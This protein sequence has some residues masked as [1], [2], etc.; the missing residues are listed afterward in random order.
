MSLKY[1]DHLY[2]LAFIDI[3]DRYDI[4]LLEIRHLQKV[5]IDSL[6]AP[7]LFLPLRKEEDY[8]FGGWVEDD[9]CC[10][11]LESGKGYAKYAKVAS[12]CV[13]RYPSPSAAVQYISTLSK[14]DLEDSHLDMPEKLTRFIGNLWAGDLWAGGERRHYHAL[15]A[16]QILKQQIIKDKLIFLTEAKHANIV[17]LKNNTP[18]RCKASLMILRCGVFEKINSYIGILR[19]HQQQFGKSLDFGLQSYPRPGIERR[20]DIG[21]YNDFLSNRTHDL[22]KDMLHFLNTF[23]DP[24]DPE[25][26]SKRVKP[27]ILHGWS[28]STKV[29][30]SELLDDVN[31]A[32]IESDVK[33]EG[34]KDSAPQHVSYIDTSF[35]SPDRPDLQPLVAKH[36][37]I[38]LARNYLGG[39]N[40]NFLSNSEDPF[41]HLLVSLH[42][43][44]NTFTAE[45]PELSSIKEHYVS[46]INDELA[47]DF[48]AASVKG[49][50]YIYA[51]FLSILGEGLEDQLRTLDKSIKLETLDDLT[52]AVRSYESHFVWYFRLR[53]TAYFLEKATQGRCSASDILILKGTREVC[54]DILDFLDS[55]VPSSTAGIPVGSLWKKLAE[56]MEECIKKHAFV[57]IAKKWRVKRSE[58]TWCEKYNT[59]GDKVYHRSTIRLDLRLQRFLFRGTLQQKLDS[60]HKPLH[61]YK[62]RLNLL[63]NEKYNEKRNKRLRHQLYDEFRDIYGLEIETIP[64][65]GKIKTEYS[66]PRW[67][68]R[69]LHHIPF[70]CAVMRSI[71]LLGSIHQKEKK[72]FS[73]SWL[74]QKKIIT[75]KHRPKPHS[76]IKFITEIHSDMSLGREKF[77]MGLE[78]Y[79]WARESPRERLALSNN[80]IVFILPQLDGGLEVKQHLTDWLQGDSSHTAEAIRETIKCQS[81]GK[82]KKYYSEIL[83]EV[84]AENINRAFSWI[85]GG[86]CSELRRLDQLAGY[87][88]KALL[89]IYYDYVEAPCLENEKNKES[90]N[91]LLAL[92][93][94][95][96]IRADEG[97]EKFYDL[98]LQA[99][100]NSSPNSVLP[101]RIPPVMLSRAVLTNYYA[102]ADPFASFDNPQGI[103]KRGDEK[104][105]DKNKVIYNA[106][107]LKHGMTLGNWSVT[108]NNDE[109]SKFSIILGRYDVVGITPARMPCKC[110]VLNFDSDFDEDEV[111]V[112]HFTRREVALPVNIYKIADKSNTTLFGIISISL[113]RRAMRLNLLYRVLSALDKESNKEI[114]PKVESSIREMVDRYSD[115]L[116]IQGY[117]TDGWGDFLLVFETVNGKQVDNKQLVEDIFHLQQMLYEDFMVDRT[118]LIYTPQCLDYVSG[119]EHYDFSISVRLLEDRKLESS[120]E[121]FIDS[122]NSESNQR[123]LRKALPDIK[124]C[125]ICQTPGRTDLTIRFE[126]KKEA[127]PKDFYKKFLNWMGGMGKDSKMSM[128]Y[129]DSMSMLDKVETTIERHSQK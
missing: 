31:L 41:S 24:A 128:W 33:E 38:S 64:V 81:N 71:D 87:K 83:E 96:K 115:S 2:L 52:G 122:F 105:E 123:D 99:F 46:L 92:G 88:L 109:L 108:T 126:L 68:F 27:M 21:I 17:K 127:K 112:N 47:V 25:D 101:E 30:G 6:H 15:R 53:I 79:T 39:I 56:E 22:H 66:L 121:N 3:T 26:L 59:A 10:R 62:K 18:T 58:D 16:L 50:A 13:S 20:R 43:V 94:F 118:E 84:G 1:S 95:L 7:T 54:D 93:A 129:P 78:F 55:N 86:N 91:V 51:L 32:L 8:L 114:L 113:Q 98:V 77:S 57:P 60:A 72:N 44:V 89:A 29:S 5:I 9:E 70:Q 76:W 4:L 19:T 49:V 103:K 34:E 63:R 106:E 61:L 124:D 97:K 73:L 42:K 65:P 85:K 104:D 12:I 119:L 74:P 82:L 36:I 11:L 111:F 90:L 23:L 35:W 120:V 69:Q 48:L 100:S 75:K 107:T 80:L 110:R 67:L 28:Q 125:S 14:E 37:A 40:D 45:T 116:H 117:I 102:V